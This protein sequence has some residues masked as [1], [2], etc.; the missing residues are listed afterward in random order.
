MNPNLEKEVMFIRNILT[1]V[2]MVAGLGLAG[3]SAYAFDS[4]S[5]VGDE[6]YTVSANANYPGTVF[7]YKEDSDVD[8]I[9]IVSTDGSERARLPEQVLETLGTN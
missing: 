9:E 7:V 4:D 8:E 1:A 6:V 5:H 2:A 3:G